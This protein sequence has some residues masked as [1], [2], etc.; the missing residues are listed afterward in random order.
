VRGRETE[1][2]ISD[3]ACLRRE[4]VRE[5]PETVAFDQGVDIGLNQVVAP[6]AFPV[7]EETARLAL[8]RVLVFSVVLRGMRHVALRERDQMRVVDRK[9]LRTVRDRIE[10]RMTVPLLVETLRVRRVAAPLAIRTVDR[11]VAVR[12]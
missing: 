7:V 6:L 2:L 4:L 8:D 9:W 5:V 12:I 3:P 11:L 1:C 10:R